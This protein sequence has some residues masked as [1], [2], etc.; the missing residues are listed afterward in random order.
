MICVGLTPP[1]AAVAELADRLNGQEYIATDSLADFW[2]QAENFAATASHYLAIGWQ[3]L[4][5][6]L[7]ITLGARLFRRGVLQSAGPKFRLAKLLGR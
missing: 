6:A 7:T 4:W 2:S 1:P 3:V 5:V